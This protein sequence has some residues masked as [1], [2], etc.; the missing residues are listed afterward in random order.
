MQKNLEENK[1]EEEECNSASLI[2]R[3]QPPVQKKLKIWK[4]KIQAWRKK[5]LFDPQVQAARAEKMRKIQKPEIKIEEEDK[6]SG[7]AK[8]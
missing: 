1:I 2:H 3:C 4:T 6:M 8:H 5:Y 7:S